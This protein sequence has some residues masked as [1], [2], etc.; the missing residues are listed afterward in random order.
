MVEFTWDDVPKIGDYRFDPM[1]NI[2]MLG[3]SYLMNISSE[4]DG[5]IVVRPGWSVVGYNAGGWMF[6]SGGVAV[7]LHNR[8]S[9]FAWQ[10]YP[11]VEK[12]MSYFKIRGSLFD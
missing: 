1:Q 3:L 6:K 7:L 11:V 2:Q 8:K 9:G 10:H 5:V 12:L 4:S